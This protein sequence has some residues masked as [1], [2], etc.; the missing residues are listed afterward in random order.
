MNPMRRCRE[1]GCRDDAACDGGCW[2]VELDLCSRC[3]MVERP[4][5]S[6]QLRD[7]ESLATTCRSCKAEVFWAQTE[8]GRKVL[9][10]I[11]PVPGGNLRIESGPGGK[12]LAI[13]V[14][15]AAEGGEPRYRSHF[16][17]CPDAAAWRRPRGRATG[18]PRRAGS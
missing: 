3:A 1:C 11:S 18:K 7:G 16:A 10:D 5:Q 12:P 15:G 13:V 8:A 2:W 9:V 17:T 4:E 6:R 14:A